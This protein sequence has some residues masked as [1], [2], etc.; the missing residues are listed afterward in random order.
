PRALLVL[1]L[2]ALGVASARAQ[3][4]RPDLSPAGQPLSPAGEPYVTPQGNIVD[5]TRQK[6]ASQGR[7]S[8]AQRRAALSPPRSPLVTQYNWSSCRAA[9]D[10]GF[11][12]NTAP[13]M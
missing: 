10:Y 13:W 9:F 7:V 12:D 5:E 2:L 6:R 8:E 1:P 3:Y 4:P 11:G